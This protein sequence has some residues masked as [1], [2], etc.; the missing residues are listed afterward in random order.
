[1]DT[2]TD[3]VSGTDKIQLDD[4]IFTRFANNTSVPSTQLVS[5]AD[6]TAARDTDDYLIF[7][8][9]N[10]ALYYDADGNGKAAAVQFATLLGISSITYED[11][12]IV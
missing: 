1:L 6:L 3:F 9:T 12:M 8:T 4:A 11:F 2:I 10:G 5:V 7:N